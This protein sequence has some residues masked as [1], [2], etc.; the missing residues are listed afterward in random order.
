M[1][2]RSLQSGSFFEQKYRSSPDP[3]HFATAKY[4][5]LRYEATLAALPRPHYERAYEPGCSVGVLTSALAR[6]CTRVEACDIAASAVARARE[7][8][9]TLPNVTILQGDVRA[10]PTI[11]ST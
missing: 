8:C 4:E 6:R 1:S 2:T 7:R 10:M 3:W 9:K 5:Q 11:A